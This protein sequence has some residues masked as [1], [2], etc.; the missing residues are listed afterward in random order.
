MKTQGE[1]QSEIGE[2]I[3]KFLQENM[4]RGPTSIK[5]NIIDDIAVVRLTGIL[6]ETEKRLAISEVGKE[7]L[8]SVRRHLMNSS[9]KDYISKLFLSKFD[10]PIINFFYD[11]NPLSNEEVFIC[12]M[13][14][15]IFFRIKMR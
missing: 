9:G 3:A 12:V 10:T 2:I 15:P 6:T 7:L 14:K 4:G 13:L 1:M 5:T 11:C 8:I